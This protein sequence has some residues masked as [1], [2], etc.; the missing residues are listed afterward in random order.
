MALL[1]EHSLQNGHLNVT[2]SKPGVDSTDVQKFADS[3]RKCYTR[4]QNGAK[5]RLLN[6]DRL[7]E[8]EELGF[9]FPN[10]CK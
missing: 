10:E 3:I 2:L 9:K 6:E 8:L 5:V 1:K 7:I 4:M